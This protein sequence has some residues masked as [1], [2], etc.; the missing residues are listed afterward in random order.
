MARFMKDSTNIP[1]LQ[2]DVAIFA[3]KHALR[4]GKFRDELSMKNPSKIADVLQMADAFIRTEEF[5]KE[6]T[7]LKGPS[8]TSDT[9]MNQS[10]PEGNSRK[11][12]EKDD[13]KWKLPDKLRS[14]PLRRNKNK[15][16]EF[17]D[18]FGH[19]TEECNS[20]K[21]NIEDLIRRGYLKQYL[22][23]Q[24]TEKE[25][26]EKATSGKL[27]EQAQ[28][29]VHETEGQKK[30]PILVVFGGQRSGHASKQHLRALSH[31]VNF[32]T[33]GENRPTPPNMNFT[34]DDCLGTQYKHDDPLVIEMD[35][36][37][38]NVHRVLVDGG[39]AVNIIFRNCFEQLILEEGEKSLTKVSYPLI[40]FNGSAGIPRGK[41]TLPVTIGQGLAARNIR[42]EFLVMDCDSVYN[43]IM[44]RT[45]IHKIQAIPSTYHQMM[46]YVLDVGFAER[47]KGDQEVARSTCHTTIQ[48]PKLGDSPEEEDEKKVDARPETLS[49]EPDQE[50]KDIPLED[51]SD[52][53]VRIG[54]GLSSG[55]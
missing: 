8:D 31:R 23:D 34:A 33:V 46:M 49:P 18:D 17:H 27:Q 28:R 47:I 53:S 36:N 30:K 45:M 38:H 32:S 13:E 15:W 14:N 9:R 37:N 5:N 43:V 39:S 19:T 4:E 44:G 35:L 11:G 52:R 25:E 10:K 12:K 24:R 55:L 21:D 40:G 1:N 29:R 41:I 51:D 50:M 22:L 7:R 54:R 42:E 20:L 16:C 2:P 48:K 26:K 3:L 6:A